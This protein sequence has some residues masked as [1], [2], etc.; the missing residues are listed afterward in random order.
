MFAVSDCV[1]VD[2]GAE[3]S[4]SCGEGYVPN[5]AVFATSPYMCPHE[6]RDQLQQPEAAGSGPPHCLALPP[7]LGSG[8]TR[9][10]WVYR[11]PSA[12][13]DNCT[14]DPRI[15]PSCDEILR[16]VAIALDPT[17]VMFPF[18]D[19]SGESLAHL[20]GVVDYCMKDMRQL[21][22]GEIQYIGQ[23][24][25]QYCPSACGGCPTENQTEWTVTD[26][27]SWC[28]CGGKGYCAPA[29]TGECMCDAGWAGDQCQI[30]TNCVE[31]PEPELEPET[32]ISGSW[33]GSTDFDDSVPVVVVPVLPPYLDG[34]FDA[35]W[36]KVILI[37]LAIPVSIVGTK[38]GIEWSKLA[39]KERKLA[40]ARANAYR[41]AKAEGAR[42]GLELMMS[43][44]VLPRRKVGPAVVVD[45]SAWVQECV[46]T[47]LR[48]EHLPECLDGDFDAMVSAHQRGWEDDW[49]HPRGGTW[50]PE[51]Y[52]L[53]LLGKTETKNAKRKDDGTVTFNTV[54]F[55]RAKREMPVWA[56]GEVILKLAD[57]NTFVDSV[58]GETTF[59]MAEPDE[60][61]R[62]QPYDY[63]PDL[64]AGQNLPPE[65]TVLVNLGKDREPVIGVD[66]EPTLIIYTVTVDAVETA[67][68]E[69]Y[70]TAS[71][72][73]S[74]ASSRPSSGSSW[75][76]VRTIVTSDS[77]PGSPVVRSVVLDAQA[78]DRQIR[79][80][81][82]DAQVEREF[83]GQFPGQ[84]DL[85][86]DDPAR[87][88]SVFGGPMPRPRGGTLPPLEA[89]SDSGPVPFFPGGGRRGAVDMTMMAAATAKEQKRLAK[90]PA[91][92]QLLRKLQVDAEAA[93]R[94]GKRA[95]SSS[96]LLA[97]ARRQNNA[98]QQKQATLISALGD[99]SRLNNTVGRVGQVR[100][101]TEKIKRGDPAMSLN[102]R[103]APDGS[104]DAAVESGADSALHQL[105][106]LA[107]QVATEQTVPPQPGLMK[108][109]QAVEA[110]RRRE[111]RWKAAQPK[112]AKAKPRRK[113]G[114]DVEIKALRGDH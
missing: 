40:K 6:N 28:R 23:S 95:A 71:R 97:V 83:Q 113:K 74:G 102:P 99:N 22:G 2:P 26:H 10:R 68:D 16:F 41:I 32:L 45:E 106:A 3:C 72:P 92:S 76:V 37:L 80:S 30:C 87:P 69:S 39:W 1:A 11:E 109:L 43:A 52:G 35:T 60:V 103:V 44:F 36:I 66:G 100:A 107:A 48:V 108:K 84:P 33:S 78:D 53:Q 25:W 34:V 51:A 49:D 111:A 98:N 93:H 9:G 50:S 75:G 73:G 17:L 65:R 88:L 12:R 104:V 21:A 4:V 110:D 38:H 27:A 19:T 55:Q 7:G 85:D 14:D 31:P 8:G 86:G 82:V 77:E 91:N 58:E 96:S 24:F 67:D 70:T 89:G 42:K 64:A 15:A 57:D 29:Y 56:P 94:Q 61:G 20:P 79:L 105:G 46:L 90:Q 63:E 5:D 112:A 18:L 101:M 13:M 59:E 47:I 62:T 114:G 81:A 54:S